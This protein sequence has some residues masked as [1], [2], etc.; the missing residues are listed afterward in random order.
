[1]IRYLDAT[2]DDEFERDYGL[3]LLVETARLWRSLGHHDA[4]G[5]FRIDG[6]T[7]PDE[8][9]AIADHNVYTNVM[10]ELNLRRAA[11]VAERQPERARALGVDPE[12]AAAWRDA[13]AAMMIPYDESLGVHP[14]AEGFTDH[15]VWDFPGTGP[16]QYPLML[17]FPYFDLYRKQ[18]V[19]QCRP[20]ARPPGEGRSLL[21]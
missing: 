1:V 19:K 4:E 5:R 10:A 7:G 6:V 21:R 14:Q 12:E 17:H 3:E 18:V 13:A 8:Y 2:G 15:A 11:D 20:R 16:D 9:S